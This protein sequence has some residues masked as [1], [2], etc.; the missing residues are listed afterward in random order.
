[1]N[2]II[3]ILTLLIT[4]VSYSQNVIYDSTKVYHYEALFID[5]TGDTLTKEKITVKSSGLPWVFQKTQKEYSVNYSPIDSMLINMPDPRN[6]KK[7]YKSVGRSR[8]VST[9]VLENKKEVWAHP[10]RSNQYVYT[11]LAPFPNVLLD[12][13]CVGKTWGED[14]YLKIMFGWGKFKG[15]VKSKYL[16]EKKISYLVGDEL[17]EGCW[18]IYGVGTHSKLGENSIRYI[19]SK[20]YGFVEMKYNFYNGVKIDFKMIEVEKTK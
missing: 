19:F 10:I 17:L 15:V 7:K 2:K 11:E 16:V 5:A 12:S 4:A 13:L 14:S 8:K 3:L 20:K 1:M 9:G 6:K 18:Q